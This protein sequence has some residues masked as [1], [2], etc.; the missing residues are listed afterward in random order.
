MKGDMLKYILDK[1]ESAPNACILT[2][3]VFH[4]ASEVPYHIVDTFYNRSSWEN[5]A[6]RYH[7]IDCMSDAQLVELYNESTKMKME[8]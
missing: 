6:Q 7:L 3:M 1:C 5:D 4:G 2:Y 8:A